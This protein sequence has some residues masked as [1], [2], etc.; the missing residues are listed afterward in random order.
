MTWVA[1]FGRWVSEFGIEAHLGLKVPVVA[2]TGRRERLRGGSE[3]SLKDGHDQEH[4]DENGGG[5]EPERH[6]IN[7]VV[8]VPQGLLSLHVVQRS[9]YWCPC[10]PFF[11]HHFP[12]L[13]F[14]F[15]F[16]ST[17]KSSRL[18]PCLRGSSWS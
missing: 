4:G 15:S 16:F 12:F 1:Y 7:R 18:T 17:P 8:E 14:S 6:S 10:V 11:F 2:A 9:P 5:N 13:L 3:E